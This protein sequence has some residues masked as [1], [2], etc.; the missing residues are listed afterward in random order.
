MKQYVKD[1]A[2]DCLRELDECKAFVISLA[3]E[4]RANCSEMMNEIEKEYTAKQ[5]R[6]ANLLKLCEL[7]YITDLEAVK[8]IASV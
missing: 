2:D 5:K 7:C 1:V 6:I 3:E 8:K 4:Q